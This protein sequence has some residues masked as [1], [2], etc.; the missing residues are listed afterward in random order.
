MGSSRTDQLAEHGHIV[1]EMYSFGP[2]GQRA[3]SFSRLSLT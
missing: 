1:L 3:T 2:Q